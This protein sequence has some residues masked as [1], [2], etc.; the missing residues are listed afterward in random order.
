MRQSFGVND[1][2]FHTML[3]CGL[4]ITLAGLNMFEQREEEEKSRGFLVSVS[5]EVVK[6]D[7]F[8]SISKATVRST[9]A[10]FAIGRCYIYFCLLS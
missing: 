8:I 4:Y 7:W 2:I 3:S 5:I 10:Q 6:A 1:T 9:R